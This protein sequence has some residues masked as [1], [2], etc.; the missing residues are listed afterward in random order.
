MAG[1]TS[2]GF[3]P[4]T[5]T[6]I[7]TEI[8]NELKAAFG[9][10][11]DVADEAPLGQLSAIAAERFALLWELIEAIVT[12]MDP[13]KATG[14]ELD[15][16]CALTG[17]V[18]EAAKSSTVTATL[19]GTAA[20]A[21]PSGSQAS[22]ASTGVKF[23]TTAN[24]TIAAVTAWAPT[25]AYVLGDR[26]NNDTPDRIYQ[27]VTAGTSA[28]SGGPTGTGTGISDNTVSWDYLGDGDGA[29]DAAA[30]SV[31]TG[32]KVALSRT[33]TTIE[34]PV[35]GWSSVINVLDAALGRDIETDAALRVRREDELAA[36]G[37]SPV[38]AIRAALL[39]VLNVTTVSLFVNNTD[40]TDGDGVPP[41]AVEALVQG[42][43]DQAIFDALLTNV[44]A[45]IATHGTTSGTA[46][47]SEGNSHAMKFTRPTEKEVYIDITLTYDA[48]LYP[49]D[50]D[51][52]VKS[53]VATQGNKSAPGKDVVSS[54]VKAWAFGVA[55]VLDVSLA[56]IGLTTS[57][58]SEATI[59]IAPR[60][61]AKYDTSRITVSSSA[62]TP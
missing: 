13:D 11:I 15:A 45:G 4:A 61:I 22:V 56:E 44:A 24:T 14:T 7:R 9:S 19:T 58:S 59:A 60:D 21:V 49:A 20:T 55:G 50:G 16:I 23:K 41:H 10:S 18:R 36:A 57:P 29:V 42:G 47:D 35:S 34:T 39:D 43:T 28:G 27:C 12:S 25:T 38:D 3:V 53:A 1:L 5:L 51:T 26:V 31:D 40:V 33:L 62:A 48:T 46:T 54:A 37:T 2:T 17:T 8:E 30:E 52:Q 6:E 32:P